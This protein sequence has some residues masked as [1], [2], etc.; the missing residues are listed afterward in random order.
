MANNLKVVDA[1]ELENA[2]TET[3]N[4]IREKTG[5]SEPM[6]WDMKTGFKDIIGTLSNAPNWSENDP[7]S[8]HYIENR[9]HWI[10]DNGNVQPI[11]E[12]FIPTSI[13]RTSDI[14]EVLENAKEYTNTTVQNIL[15]PSPN[16]NENNSASTSYI[17]G[18][19][20]WIDASGTYHT[21]NEHF[22]PNTI[23]RTDSVL[24]LSAQSLTIEQQTQVRTN[25][26]AAPKIQYGTEE[27]AEG[28]TSPYPEGTLY[29]VIL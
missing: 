3:A 16:W 29:V 25:L 9:T 23:A 11:N 27:V 13:A 28:A 20:H 21:L 26:N 24:A 22:I 10:D 4:A 6:T 12:K 8:M 18:R 1:N 19:T 17:Q 14:T 15:F 7:T 5:T 2:L